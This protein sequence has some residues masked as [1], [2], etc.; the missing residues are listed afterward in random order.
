MRAPLATR[1]KPD[2]TAVQILANYLYLLA[3]FLNRTTNA[4]CATAATEHV[5]EMLHQRVD[6]ALRRGISRQ[7]ADGAA[8]R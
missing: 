7:G 5:G 3:Q 6:C 2:S 8:G 4:T 1:S